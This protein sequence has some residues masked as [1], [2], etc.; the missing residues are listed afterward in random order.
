MRARLRDAGLPGAGVSSRCSIADEPLAVSRMPLTFPCV[1]KPVALS[2]SR[3]V[4]RADDA[5]AFAA[6][7]ERLRA[8]LRSPDVRSERNDAH[9]MRC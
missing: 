3:G 7:F 6:A 5:T 1:V 2:G 8:L 9:T 4:M